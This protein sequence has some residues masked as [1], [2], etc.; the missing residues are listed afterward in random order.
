MCK[1]LKIS[2]NTAYYKQATKKTNTELENLIISIFENSKSSYGT[3]K[4]RKKLKDKSYN[5]SRKTI[6]KVMN[7][8]ALVSKYTVKNFKVYKG[9]CNEEEVENELD[10]NFKP[11][12]KQNIF[13]SDLTYVNIKGK[14]HYICI[15]INI[16]NREI[17][18]YSS[19]RNKDANIV[20][21]AFASVKSP[22]NNISI[23]HTDRGKEFKNEDIDKILDEFNIKRSLSKK[24]CPY[25]NA[26]AEATFKIIKTELVFGV[27]FQSLEELQRELFDYVNWYNNERIHG[28]LGYL[29]PVEFKEKMFDKK[30]Y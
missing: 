8:Y 25:D 12:D 4:I 5:I 20:K 29:T 30:M 23:F 18:G 6:K 26:V 24:G 15:L 17:V 2:R 28:S 10:R 16:F 9:K 27:K 19:S 11:G 1:I 21:R 14:W 22:L 3:R 7:K 13:V